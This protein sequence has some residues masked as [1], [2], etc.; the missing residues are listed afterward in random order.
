MIVRKEQNGAMLLVAQTDHSRLAGQFA[1]HWGNA[2]FAPL[3]PYESVARAA[4]FHDFGYL[5]YETAPAFV[6]ESGETPMFR[7]VLTDAQRLEEYEWCSGWLLGLDPYAALLV[8]MHRTGL[9]RQR[10]KTIASAMHKHKA[11]KPEV[12]AFIER[13]EAE[14]PARIAENGF[15]PKQVWTNYRLLQV[16]DLMSLYFSCDAPSEPHHIE[17]VPTSYRD[18]EDEGVRITLTPVDAT[19]VTFDPYPFDVQ[20]LRVTLPARRFSQSKF[21]SQD[22]FRKAYFSA[23]LELMEFELRAP[24][25]SA[26]RLREAELT[27][28][29]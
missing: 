12:E 11:Q 22:A 29:G 18:K 7:D 24:A 14:R 5:R 28:A 3:T 25:P 16:W 13:Y 2:D 23:Q 21:E 9:W 15:D 27:V 17:P 20:S 19:T 8:S 4:A 26:K 6:A 1:A 10:Y